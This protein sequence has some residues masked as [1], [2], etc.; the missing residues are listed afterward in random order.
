MWMYIKRNISQVDNIHDLTQ[1]KINPSTYNIQFMFNLF[2]RVFQL[3]SIQLTFIND[4][5]GM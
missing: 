1:E 3:L 4:K 2:N 5:L